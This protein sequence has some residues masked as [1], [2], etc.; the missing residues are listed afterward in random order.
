MKVTDF[1]RQ[2]SII[3]HENKALKALRSADQRLNKAIRLIERTKGL[4]HANMIEYKDVCAVS[5]CIAQAV[6]VIKGVIGPGNLKEV[7]AFIE[8]LAGKDSMRGS[9]D[10]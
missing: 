8:A 9:I 5:L 3:R 1:F 7:Q 2:I 6:K 4:S 10:G